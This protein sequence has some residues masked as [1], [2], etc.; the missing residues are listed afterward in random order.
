[1]D[2]SYKVRNIEATAPEPDEEL[3]DK[4]DPTPT[5]EEDKGEK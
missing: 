1:M 4:V 5:V 2:Y 3:K